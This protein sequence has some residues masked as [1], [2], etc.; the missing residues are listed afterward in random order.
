MKLNEKK[1][2]NIPPQSTN[3]KESIKG[4]VLQITTTGGGSM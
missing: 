1:K 4:K 2:E 3:E